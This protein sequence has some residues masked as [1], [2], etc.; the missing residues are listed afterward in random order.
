M[1][2]RCGNSGAEEEGAES[3]NDGFDLE[4]HGDGEVGC[5]L[6]CW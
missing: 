5:F 6:G 2:D 4:E 3:E 1:L